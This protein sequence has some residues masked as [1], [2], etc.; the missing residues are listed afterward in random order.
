[1][2][3]PHEKSYRYYTIKLVRLQVKWYYEYIAVERQH[4]SNF[5]SRNERD[6]MELARHHQLSDPLKRT[7]QRSR[8]MA[9]EAGEQ[10][11]KPEHLLYAIIEHRN[12]TAVSVLKKM[13]LQL[14]SMLEI[15]AE[16]LHIKPRTVESTENEK[17]FSTKCLAIIGHAIRLSKEVGAEY[18]K[19]EHILLSMLAEK[20]RPE[21]FKRLGIPEAEETVCPQA[22]DNARSDPALVL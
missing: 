21:I 4:I 17:P 22:H 11:T 16:Y 9:F 19:T 18:V 13:K 7:M 1:M 5:T 20:E 12:N 3:F 2:D 15:L 10:E 14:T 8:Q 6:C